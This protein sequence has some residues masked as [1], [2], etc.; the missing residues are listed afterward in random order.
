MFQQEVGLYNVP[1]SNW[2]RVKQMID[3]C[4]IG[5]CKVRV[6]QWHSKPDRAAAVL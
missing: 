3:G 6:E 4:L 5:G 2:L 1:M